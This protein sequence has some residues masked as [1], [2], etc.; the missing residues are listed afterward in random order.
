MSAHGNVQVVGGDLPAELA[1]AFGSARSIAWDVETTGLDWRTERL[2]T[3]QLFAEGVGAAVVGMDNGRPARLA[4][5][6]ENPVVEKVFHHAQF[7]LRFM[8]GSW[9]VQPTSIRCTKVASKLLAPGSP[10]EAHSLQH[11]V[12]RHLGVSLAK[13]PVRTSDWTATTLTKEQIDYAVGDVVHLLALLD[14]L[15]ASLGEAR[16]TRLYDDCCAFLP[17]RVALELGGYPDVF[18]Y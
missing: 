10:N 3:C 7:D 4:A 12:G 11:L 17:A 8:V 2:A 9:G 6:L 16:L 5:L 15:R 1:A 14:V 18:A 13:G